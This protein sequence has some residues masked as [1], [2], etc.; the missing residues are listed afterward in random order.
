MEDN[1]KENVRNFIDAVV[2]NKE[3]DMQKYIQSV[4]KNKINKQFMDPNAI[5][6]KEPNNPVMTPVEPQVDVVADT[7]EPSSE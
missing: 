5:S 6:E 7:I 3:E 2:A 1:S 4:I